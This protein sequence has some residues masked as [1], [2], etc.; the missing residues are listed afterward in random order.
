MAKYYKYGDAQYKAT[1]KYREKNIKRVVLLLNRKTDAD[2]IEYVE[3]MDNVNREIKQVI[4][5]AMK[6]E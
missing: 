6:E 1:Q 2:I 5:N 3:Q 4:R